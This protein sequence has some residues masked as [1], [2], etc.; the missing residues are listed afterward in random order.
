MFFWFFCVS[1]A[2]SPYNFELHAG[3]T[4]KHP[5]DY[6][7]LENGNSMRDVLKAC[8]NVSL[9]TLEDAIQNAIGPLPAERSY[10]CQ[11]CKREYYALGTYC[12][13]L[14]ILV[15]YMCMGSAESFLTSRTGKLALLCDVCLDSKAKQPRKT[16]S[17]S[18]ANAS[19]SRYFFGDTHDHI[20]L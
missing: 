2:V 7:I 9:A 12:F 17:P 1:Q 4:K 6:I 16:P 20:L 19:G 14:L 5:S 15:T 11:K 8:A 18:N 13:V 10:T 3:S